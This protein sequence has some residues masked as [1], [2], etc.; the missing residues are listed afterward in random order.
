MAIQIHNV[1]VDVANILNSITDLKEVTPNYPDE[2][3]TFPLAVYQTM[4]KTFIRNADNE[5]TDTQW[6]VTIDAFKQQGSLTSIVDE[7]TDAFAHIGF[8]ATVQQANQTGFNRSI[9]TLT[10]VVDNTSGRVY[11]AS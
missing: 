2:V 9:I 7:I 5:E 3:T 4:R 6:T 10:A 8:V 11:Q 1:N